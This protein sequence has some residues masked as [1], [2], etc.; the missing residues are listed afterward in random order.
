[1]PT[2]FIRIDT[3]E[4]DQAEIQE[5]LDIIH[6]NPEKER[7]R[8]FGKRFLKALMIASIKKRRVLVP[9]PRPFRTA[10]TPQTIK[11]IEKLIPKPKIKPVTEKKEIKPIPEI[12]PEFK[13]VTYPL[14]VSEEGP[15]ASAEIK[16]EIYN[17]IEPVINKKILDYAIKKLK[18]KKELPEK[19]VTTVVKKVAK[20]FKQQYTPDLNKKVKYFL[21]RDYKNL[22]KIDPLIHDVNIDTITCSGKDKPIKINHR[23]FG[24]LPTNIILTEKEIEKLIEK[25]ADITKTK[26]DKKSPTINVLIKGFRFQ[27]TLGFG[28]IDSKF[29]MK[30]E[31]I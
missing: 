8:E 1:M 27:G 29:V 12:Q 16:K 25:V 15:L 30:K 17:V 22:G 5:I 18:R 4:I 31:N 13:P 9:P 7:Q 20:K 19:L 28:K 24:K 10:I 21:F 14:L 3:D 11:K 23:Q 26:I 6:K 2:R